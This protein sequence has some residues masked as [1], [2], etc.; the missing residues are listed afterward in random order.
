[1]ELTQTELE[2]LWHDKAYGVLTRPAIEIEY[3]RRSAGQIHW[4]IFLDLDNIH[5]LN[6]QFASDT[7]DGYSKVDEKVR[8]AFA[9]V[10]STDLL[11]A[12]RFKSG[13]EVVFLIA[14][15]PERFCERLQTSLNEQG[16]SATMAYTQPLQDF[17]T[18]IKQAAIQVKRAKKK[19]LRGRVIRR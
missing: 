16:L 9:S 8:A 18:T 10:R 7:E 1:M 19:N 3:N 12:G 5:N 2:Q 6:S 13:D 4:V 11:V 14:G 15:D 17:E